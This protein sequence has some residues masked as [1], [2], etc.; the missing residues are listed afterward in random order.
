MTV[1]GIRFIRSY[2]VDPFDFAQGHPERLKGVE[3]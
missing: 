3:G 2:V 1:T